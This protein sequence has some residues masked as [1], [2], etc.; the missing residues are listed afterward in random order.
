MKDTVFI[1]QSMGAKD[2]FEMLFW[3]INAAI[4]ALTVYVIRKSPKD[5][6]KIG[7]E[8]NEAQQKDNAKRE[9]F[10][11]LF[12][13]KGDPV[14]QYF[15]DGLNRIDVVF[16]DVPK[17]VEAWHKYY[18]ALCNTG[19]INKEEEWRRLRI[20]LLSQMSINLGYQSM[21]HYNL[22]KHYT[23]E[24]HGFRIEKGWEF[25]QAQFDYYKSQR[26]LADILIDIYK[27]N[28]PVVPP[29][30]APPK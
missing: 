30:E 13:Y 12:S 11:T 4:L 20:E 26:E 6:I 22:E 8:L 23:P 7:R 14:H 19:L 10:F 2:Y 27:N 9:L 18:D 17:V 29:N 1:A 24:G 21:N 3:I 5:A 28:P 15:V 25:W 16:D